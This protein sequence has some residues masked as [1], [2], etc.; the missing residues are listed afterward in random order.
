MKTDRGY[1]DVVTWPYEAS[2]SKAHY[3]AGPWTTDLIRLDDTKLI[4]RSRINQSGL[5]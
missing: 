4:R 3:R 1:I 5:F 2:L